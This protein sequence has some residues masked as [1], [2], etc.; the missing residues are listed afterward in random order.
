ML[1][2][3]AEK[4]SCISTCASLYC[5]LTILSFVSRS[6]TMWQKPRSPNYSI[7]SF[8][9]TRS[10][11]LGLA[12]VEDPPQPNEP[13]HT[14]IFHWR[15]RHWCWDRVPDQKFSDER[16]TASSNFQGWRL[17]SRTFDRAEPIS[18]CYLLS[19]P[20]PPCSRKITPD[21]TKHVQLQDHDVKSFE[22]NIVTPG[23]Y[24]CPFATR[25]P[26]TALLAF[27]R[28]SYWVESEET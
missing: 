22:R 15:R 5:P 14:D 11:R 9:G 1:L 24:L 18:L 8:T 19:S 20:Q 3:L 17:Q 21:V 28:I 12:L 25:E 2:F 6:T 7:K 27:H 26:R 13:L 4:R 16:P 10:R 23:H